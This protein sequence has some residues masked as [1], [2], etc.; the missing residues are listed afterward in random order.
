MDGA[1][2]LHKINSFNDWNYQFE[3]A[4][5]KTTPY[6][7]AINRH[8]QRKKYFF[9]P[10]VDLLGGSLA[11]KR[12]L[13][14][15]CNQGFWSL[16]AVENGC[17]YVLGIDGRQT[18]IDQ[19]KFVFDVKCINKDRYNFRAGNIFDLLNED[20]G[21][22]DIVL[23]LGLMYHI[24]KHMTLLE[25]ISA[26]NTDLLVI[27]TYLSL[28]RT[29]LL[30]IH[31]ESLDVQVNAID[32]ELVMRPTKTAILDMVHQFK[33]HTV[34]LR[35]SFS[36][37]TG[38]AQYKKGSRRAFIC[39]K[40]TDLTPLKAYAEPSGG[41]ESVYANLLMDVPGKDMVYALAHRVMHRLG[42]RVR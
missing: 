11:G 19:A 9:R 5:H 15:G 37:Y 2:I 38:A 22:F 23:C 13:D 12:V 36:D 17:D 6:S 25:R 42:L 27:D 31:K 16:A 29:S 41:T 24:S 33:Y 26:L 18:H 28:M 34:V 39:A 8:A 3:L 30:Q 35:P 32:Y 20:L 1:E 21:K 4:G 7:D 14:L 40:L 10:L